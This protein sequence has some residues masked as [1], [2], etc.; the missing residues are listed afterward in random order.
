MNK[1]YHRRLIRLEGYDYSLPGYYFVTV[2]VQGRKYMLGNV[3]NGKMILSDYGQI[4]K[5]CWN[6]LPRHYPYIRLDAF[7]VMPNHIH[8]IIRIMRNV[9]AG[10]QPALIELE[11]TGFKPVPTKNK[12]KIT[13]H[14]L[15][16]IVRAFKTFSARGI[17]RIRGVT[18][19]KFWQRN[20]YDHIIRNEQELN[21]IREYIQNNRSA[22]RG[23]REN[24]YSDNFNIKHAIYWNE[25]FKPK[26]VQNE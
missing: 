14:G 21:Q 13:R 23:D 8:G 17:N 2:C 20:Y 4:V 12:Q 9:G 1:I 7:V 6:D 25:V 22:W 3:A 18:G 19:T 24:P 11:R 10:L 26:E 5:K 16:E 15:P